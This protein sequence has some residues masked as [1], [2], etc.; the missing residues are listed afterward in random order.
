MKTEILDLRLFKALYL[1]VAGIV[2]TQILDLDRMTSGLFLLTFPMTVVLWLRSV[3]KTV[4]GSDLLMLGTAALA[5]VS[6]LIDSSVTGAD[7]NF[8]YLKKMIMFTMTLLF[9][10]TAHRTRIDKNFKEFINRLVDI[11]TLFFI[12]MYFARFTQMH[13]LNGRVTVYLTFRFTN[14]NLTGLF[15]MCLYMLQ[16]YRLFTPARWYQKL[17]HIAMA[18]MIALFVFQ[19]QSRNCLLALVLFTGASA[20]LIFRGRWN[21]RI[22][23]F[24]AALITAIP[25]LF[26]G[27]Y[28]V[29]VYT[30]WVQKIF[31]FLVGEGKGLDARVKVWTPGLKAVWESPLIGAYYH[32]SEGTGI[33]QLHN[34]HLDIAASY[35]I[36]VLIIVMILLY[37]YLYQRGKV[38]ADKSSYLYM[39]GFA[40]SILL[41]I[42]EAVL[43]SG[44]LGIYVFIGA[45]LLLANAEEDEPQQ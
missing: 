23:K 12:L 24:W 19:T 33:S 29:V 21:L 43:F 7:L 40:C 20:W 1:I 28:M 22:T 4:T 8:D 37:R 10:Q 25:V 17:V 42:G 44:G 35:G 41:G 2:V 34:T 39:L 15:L 32:I 11:L 16:V 14:P 45:F 30:E 5:A 9:L 36:P 3:R 18:V 38:Y 27:V 26:I 13:M 31:A 6:V